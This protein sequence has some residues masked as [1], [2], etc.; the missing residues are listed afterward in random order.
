M[1][2]KF[3]P[4]LNVWKNATG[5]VFFDGTK[6]FSYSWFC[7]ALVL[8][9]GKKVINSHNYSNT[10][11][12]HIGDMRKH[13]EYEYMTLNAPRGLLDIEATAMALDSEEK[14]LK[15]QLENPRNKKEGRLARLAEIKQERKLNAL[16]A[17]H[18]GG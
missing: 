15:E 6:A 18:F 12:K 9:N 1:A 16:I 17:K 13:F 2:L 8:P 7:I 3:F 4:R 10:T 11:M 14:D 5:K